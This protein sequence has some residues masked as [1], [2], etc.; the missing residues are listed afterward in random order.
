MD[1]TLDGKLVVVG[2]G[3]GDVGSE[4]DVEVLRLVDHQ[5]HVLPLEVAKDSDQGGFRR[6]E[7]RRCADEV[8]ACVTIGSVEETRP[9]HDRNR[10]LHAIHR[11][12]ATTFS[13]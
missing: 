12:A 5:H 10:I 9:G 1:K 11:R 13:L 7:R 4:V 2:D 3:V 6:L 8:A